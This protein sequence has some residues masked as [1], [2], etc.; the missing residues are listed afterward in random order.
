MNDDMDSSQGEEKCCTDSEEGQRECPM[1]LCHPILINEDDDD[2]SSSSTY[3]E[4]ECSTFPLKCS[5]FPLKAVW[6]REMVAYHDER[7]LAVWTL[8]QLNLKR[9][10]ED[11]RHDL[12]PVELIKEFVGDKVSDAS[13][14]LL[15]RLLHSQSHTIHYISLMTAITFLHDHSGSGSPIASTSYR[16]R[17]RM[18]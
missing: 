13:L 4:C 2:E 16:D 15:Y 14:I 12:F 17:S 1:S 6:C 8:K 18:W 9:F 7:V 10:C 5:K 3:L 11:W